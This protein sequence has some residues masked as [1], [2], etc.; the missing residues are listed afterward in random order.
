MKRPIALGLSPN[1][2][3]EDVRLSLQLLCSP[4][5]FKKGN[6]IEELESWFK[7]FFSVSHAISFSNA[8]SALYAILWA[9]GIT[10]GDEVILQAF[11]CVVVPDAILA[12]G[13]KP[14]YADITKS[15]TLDVK[16]IEKKITPKT[17]AI[18]VQHT[19]GIPTDMDGVMRIAKAHKL[20]VIEDVA[21]TI[22]EDYKK[23]KLG[24]FGVAS[25]FSFGR[26]KA[27]SSVFGGMA[28]TSDNSLGKRIRQYQRMRGYPSSLWIAQQLLHPIAFSFVLPLYDMLSLGKILL[29]ILQR[30]K[31][32]SFPVS[33]GEKR[34]KF[35]PLAVQKFPNALAALALLQLQKL[36]R[37]NQRRKEIAKRYIDRID[38]Y[39]LDVAYKKN[40]SFLRFPIFMNHPTTA[41]EYFRK[42][43]IYIGDWYAHVIDPRN[44]N[45][46]AIGYARGSCPKAE[47]A[48]RKIVNLPTY[49]T[50]TDDDVQTVIETLKKYVSQ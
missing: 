48:S 49:P 12:T 3:S 29:V 26:D 34:G 19:F 7:N 28:I 8:R 37:Y 25:I 18:L 33:S 23:K 41:R 46:S 22:G 47:E 32:L 35:S 15:L 36:H 44:S 31:L 30:L 40:I 21:H 6:A 42:S 9:L 10:A 39:K 20:F 5:K 17:K 13:A 43:Q 2:E 24:T 11:T 50:M 45:L 38:E 27:F 16:D 4:W 14:V 1:T